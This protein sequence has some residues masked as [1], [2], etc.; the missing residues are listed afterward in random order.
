MNKPENVESCL[1]GQINFP[2]DLKKYEFYKQNTFVPS[3][4]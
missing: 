1:L 4:R 2:S 3:I